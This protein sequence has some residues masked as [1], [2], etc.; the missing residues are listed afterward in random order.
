MGSAS[1]SDAPISPSQALGACAPR[2]LRWP[3]ALLLWLTPSIAQLLKFAGPPGALLLIGAAAIGIVCCVRR[4]TRLPNML[5]RRR[6][7]DVGPLRENGEFSGFPVLA[8][9]GRFGGRRGS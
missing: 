6:R 3:V 8:I 2:P 4:L 1:G 9:G 5:R 7:P